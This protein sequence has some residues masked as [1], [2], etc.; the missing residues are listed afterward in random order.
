MADAPPT[1]V[2]ARVI[3]WELEGAFG[4]GVAITWFDRTHEAY[5]VGNRTSARHEIQ[6]LLA[7]DAPLKL[8]PPA[9]D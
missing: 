5:A 3:P 6:R 1:I 7:G 8:V 4:Y 2:S 9:K